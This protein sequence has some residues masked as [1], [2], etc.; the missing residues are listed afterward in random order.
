MRLAEITR[1]TE[2]CK[3]REAADLADAAVRVA[4]CEDERGT[5]AV[6]ETDQDRAFWDAL[7]EE[8]SGMTDAELREMAADDPGAIGAR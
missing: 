5:A 7:R 3:F 8:L 2:L 4:K 6:E 1:K